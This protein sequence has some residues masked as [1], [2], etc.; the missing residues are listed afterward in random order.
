MKAKLLNGVLFNVSWLLIVLS[1]DAALAWLVASVH[2]GLHMALLGRGREEWYF[3]FT[4]TAIGL[5]VDQLLF[6][7][8]VLQ[9]PGAAPVAP[10]WLSALWPVLATTFMH[11]FS[12]LGDRPWLAAVLGAFGGYGSYR[13]GVSLSS[14]EFGTLQ[15]SGV[16]LA[17]FWA[18]MFPTLLLVARKFTDL[19]KIGVGHAS[20]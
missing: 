4:I 18:L 8:G 13:L 5:V 10:L 6:V 14:I 3:V 15:Q 11:A 19:R 16:V 9:S 17:L 7:S 12:T 20:Y 2:V 1:Q